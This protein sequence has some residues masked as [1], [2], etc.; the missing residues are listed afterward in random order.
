MALSE[1]GSLTREFYIAEIGTWG[2]Y[3]GKRVWR[4]IGGGGGAKKRFYCM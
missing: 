3:G 2:N 4:F 1:F